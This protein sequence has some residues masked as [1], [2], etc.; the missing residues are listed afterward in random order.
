MSSHILDVSVGAEAMQLIYFIGQN[1]VSVSPQV[2]VSGLQSGRTVNISILVN[3]PRYAVYLEGR[4]VIDIRHDVLA[5]FRG[6]GF[7]IFGQTGT[8]RLTKLRIF[9]VD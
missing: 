8:V 4:P 5:A 6:P 2:A 9:H 7:G 3:P 1:T